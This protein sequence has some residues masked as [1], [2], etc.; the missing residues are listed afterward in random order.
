MP[1]TIKKRSGERARTLSART[2]LPASV[3]ASCIACSLEALSSAIFARSRGCVSRVDGSG[4]PPR[5]ARPGTDGGDKKGPAR[6]AGGARA[7]RNVALVSGTEQNLERSR[8]ERGADMD[9]ETHG[10]SAS[11]KP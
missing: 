11:W 6:G 5:E 2:S 8:S 9:S 4:A 10:G 1:E 7:S 3:T